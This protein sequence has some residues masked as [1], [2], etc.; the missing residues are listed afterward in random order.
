[1]HRNLW[2]LGCIASNFSTVSL[3]L[4]TG[5]SIEEGVTVKNNL[6]SVFRKFS[7]KF[8]SGWF[9]LAEELVE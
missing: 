7:R 3:E 1:M 2:W 6:I 4:V 9:R 8:E 5:L